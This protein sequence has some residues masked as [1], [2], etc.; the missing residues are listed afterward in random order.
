MLIYWCGFLV[1]VLVMF[2]HIMCLR[3]NCRAFRQDR[4][5]QQEGYQRALK[6]IQSM[7]AKEQ[8]QVEPE[9]ASGSGV[10]Q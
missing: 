1:V 8:E 6:I 3:R 7:Q 2:A 4:D 9:V 5:A 10:A